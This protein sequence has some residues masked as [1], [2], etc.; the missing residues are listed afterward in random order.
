M[1]QAA[2]ESISE[3]NR[4]FLRSQLEIELNYA[5]HNLAC[6]ARAAAAANAASARSAFCSI[7][8]GTH[9]SNKCSLFDFIRTNLRSVYSFALLTQRL[10]RH[11]Q[12]A[13]TVLT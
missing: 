5:L 11:L 12:V 8:F 7:F 9:S 4:Q 10:Q 3:G 6:G 1:T 2:L 13:L